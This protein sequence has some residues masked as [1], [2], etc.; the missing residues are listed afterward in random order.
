MASDSKG[1]FSVTAI[2]LIRQKEMK[3]INLNTCI[4]EHHG[5]SG[6]GG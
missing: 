6:M 4:S 1:M 2:V 3:N 5:E